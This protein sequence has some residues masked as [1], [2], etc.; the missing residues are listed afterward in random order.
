MP[1]R[2][3]MKLTPTDNVAAGALASRHYGAEINDDG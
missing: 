3:N 1:T 2:E